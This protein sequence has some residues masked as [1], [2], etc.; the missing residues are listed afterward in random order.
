MTAP[1]L[2]GIVVLDLSRVLAGPWC[3]M[4][5]GDLGARVIKVENPAGGDDTRKWGPPYAGGEAAYYLCAN[6]NKLS[7]AADFKD[8]E[9]LDIVRQLARR[10]DV[11]IENFKLDGLKKFGLDYDTLAAENPGLV[12]CSISGYGRTGSRAAEP[13]YDFVIQAEGGLMSVTG[14]ADGE[15]QKVGVAIADL[16]TGASSAQA[17]LAALYARQ[18]TGRGQHIDMALLDCQIA[19]LANVGSSCLVTG[20]PAKRYGNAH[21]TVV[22]Y[23]AVEASDGYFVIAIGN[24][25]QFARLSRDVLGRP[26]LAADERFAGNPGRIVNREALLIE[27]AAE[28]RKQPRDHWIAVMRRFGLPVGPIRGVDEALAAPEV[29]ERGMVRTVPHPTAGEVRLAGSPL[30]L[31]GTPVVDPVAPPLLG[32]HSLAVLRADLGWSEERASDYCRR[33]GVPG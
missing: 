29:A 32:Q 24:D 8:P 9:G 25:G 31:S 27:L 28:F 11:L 15:P 26:D 3:G 21:G 2:D 14:E 23:Q 19:M 33:I 17:V 10:A 12:Y 6:R 4:V 18:T 1:A 16:F 20:E 13:G 30:K 5:L 22:P 7:L